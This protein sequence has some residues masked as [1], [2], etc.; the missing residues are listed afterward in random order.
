MILHT[1]A[2]PELTG[3]ASADI[4]S[5]REW[6]GILNRQLRYVTAGLDEGIRAANAAIA[7]AADSGSTDNTAETE[8]TVT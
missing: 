6:C 3:N 4:A 5:L 7:A 8:E 1:P 2:P